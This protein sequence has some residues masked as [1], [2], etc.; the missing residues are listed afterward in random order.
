MH[1]TR[2]SQRIGLVAPYFP[3]HIGGANIYCH[4]LAKAIAEK[5]YE[6]HVFAHRDAQG[7]GGYTLHPILKLA[8]DEDLAQLAAFDMDVWHSLF[9]FYAPL[10]LSRRNVFI[11]G[12]GDDFYSFRIRRTLPARAFLRQHLLWRLPR[13]AQRPIEHALQRAEL[14]M[15]RQLYKRA[16]ERARHLIAV[17]TFSKARL[18][19]IFPEATGKTTV[20]PPGV[21]T[22]FFDGDRVLKEKHLLLTVTRLDETDRIK[23]VHGVIQALAELK[24]TY[25][26][27]YRVIAGAVTGGYRR[28]LEQMVVDM[29]LSQKVSIEGRKT[30]DEL[31]DCYARADLFIL[32]S[33]AESQNFEGFGI[34]FLEANAAGTPVLTTREG[35]MVDYVREGVNGYFSENPT[36]AGLKAA[37]RRYLDGEIR[38]D[39]EA[40][41][42]APEPYRWTHIADRVLGVYAAYGT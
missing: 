17:S 13:A 21:A 4:E 15:N 1:G 19:E 14:R 28:E 32:A 9:F 29:G 26:F 41:R 3:P 11:T 27:R 36:A 42:R 2:K 20:I 18:C 5:G 34:V 31:A 39:P 33:Y 6:V 8:L 7:D 40:V 10:A 24:D 35:G 22:R 25:D 16:L 37:I 12:H 23:N 38:F 30:E